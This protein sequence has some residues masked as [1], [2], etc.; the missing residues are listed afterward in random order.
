MNLNKM[1]RNW[2]FAT[3]DYV[4]CSPGPRAERVNPRDS[5]GRK[6]RETP[7]GPASPAGTTALYHLAFLWTTSSLPQ[8]RE[9]MQFIK[10]H[11]SVIKEFWYPSP[12][13]FHTAT[14]FKQK[15]FFIALGGSIC[16]RGVPFSISRFSFFLNFNHIFLALTPIQTSK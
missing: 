13:V 4:W 9:V 16:S 8:N 1:N 10:L 6:V 3:Q 7:P 12:F 15:Y 5:R 2:L 14:R 11:V